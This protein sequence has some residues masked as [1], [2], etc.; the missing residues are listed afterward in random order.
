MSY[1]GALRNG[2]PS[3]QFLTQDELRDLVA[4]Q[5]EEVVIVKTEPRQYAGPLPLGPSRLTVGGPNP[6]DPA[7]IAVI[8][9]QRDGSWR[10][11]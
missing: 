1:H 4:S 6:S 11:L 5:P 7:W 9:R 3:R 8:E 10:V 2:A